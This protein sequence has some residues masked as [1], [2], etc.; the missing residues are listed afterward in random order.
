VCVCPCVLRVPLCASVPPQKNDTRQFR[1]DLE[2]DLDNRN[3]PGAVGHVTVEDAVAQRYR[4]KKGSGSGT[5][6][7]TKEKNTGRALVSSHRLTDP[8]CQC[9]HDLT[10]DE[11]I[12][13]G[14]SGNG[15]RSGD[16][17]LTMRIEV[18]LSGFG[19]PSVR[20]DLS[21]SGLGDDELPEM[22]EII[23]KN[24][25][26]RELCLNDNQIGNVGAMHLAAMLKE[27]NPCRF[28]SFQGLHLK[29]AE[30]DL[31]N[32]NIGDVGATHLAQALVCLVQ[33]LVQ[34]LGRQQ[35]W[36]RRRHTPC[37]GLCVVWVLTS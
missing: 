7:T 26:L 16:C 30:L 18:Q 33:G 21:H 3:P 5:I 37:P 11:Q 13:R 22:C 14:I 10:V 19:M 24:R 32:N 2:R 6:W 4:A 12:A 1:L 17:P 34:G 8:E 23:K 9:R 31:G 27:S 29:L 36:R 35:H 15:M 25:T 20:L 28:C